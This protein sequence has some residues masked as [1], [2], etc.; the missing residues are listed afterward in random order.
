MGCYHVLDDIALAD[1]ALE[2]EGRDPADVFATAAAALADLMVDPATLPGGVTRDVTLAASA[3]DLLLYDFL[4]E[5][6]FRKD[7]DLEVF[8]TARVRIGGDGPFTLAATLAGGVIDP[9]RTALR[10]DA[11]AVTMH[12]LRVEPAA[13]GW[14]AR[15]VIDV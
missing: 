11:K 8:P 7:R 10:A 15:V 6:I 2:I 12:E 3:L 1:C 13:A 9:A 14:R 4:A 5:L